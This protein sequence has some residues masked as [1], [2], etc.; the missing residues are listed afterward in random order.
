MG[1]TRDVLHGVALILS[2]AG[3]GTYRESGAYLDTETGIVIGKVPQTPAAI[4]ALN[5]YPLT[6]DATL[7][8]SVL[9]M[10]VRCRVDGQDP[11]DVTDLTDAVF[12]VLQA[13]P[14]TDL[15]PTARLL[16]AERTSGVP[17]G[18]DSNGRP[19]WADSYQLQLHRPSRHRT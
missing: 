11:R 18:E 15:S 6:D 2:G 1:F 5:P 3:V 12:D 4:I 17:L 19:E 8:D 13:H 7:S 10:Q 16:I 14:S 9:G